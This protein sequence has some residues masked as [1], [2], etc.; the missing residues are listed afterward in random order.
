[1]DFKVIIAGSRHFNNYELLRLKVDSILRKK[2][3]EGYKIIIISGRAKG[4][5][6][7]GE[8]YAKER[9]YELM[10]FPAE[11]DIYGKGAGP[12]RNGKMA[13]EADAL[14]A[15]LFENSRGTINMIKQA[16]KKGL[17]IRVI[18]L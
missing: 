13:D 5:D 6:T 18:R 8:R 7:L 2:I 17:K 15:F 10:L 16:T 14:I 9:K 3:E 1:M 12:I 4:A 11:W